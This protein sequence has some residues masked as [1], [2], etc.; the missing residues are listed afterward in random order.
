M[1][2]RGLAALIGAIG[3]VFGLVWGLSSVSRDGF[4]CGS[5]FHPK[6][7]TSLSFRDAIA[8]DNGDLFGAPDAAAAV[9]DCPSALSDR[10]PIAW[11]AAGVGG[12]LLLG[13]GYAFAVSR[14]SEVD[15]SAPTEGMPPSA[16][17]PESDVEARY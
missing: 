4:S 3:L 9:T 8:K 2:A 6:D 11:T 14:Q 12:A 15:S 1:S 5:A 17:P 7:L 13:A 16:A 10:K